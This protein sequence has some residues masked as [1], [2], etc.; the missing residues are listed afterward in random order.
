MARRALTLKQLKAEKGWPYSRQHTNRLIK[1]DKFLRPFKGTAGG[2]LNLFWEDEY[3]AWRSVL[4]NAKPRPTP[5]KNKPDHHD[6]DR[7]FSVRAR[8]MAQRTAR[9]RQRQSLQASSIL[10]GSTTIPAKGVPTNEQIYDP[11]G[12]CKCRHSPAK[13]SEPVSP[14]R[15]AGG[16]R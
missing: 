2:N 6:G 3:D 12:A 14:P 13:Q 9:S 8:L 15:A 16:R 1:A 5:R 11:N 4:P 10:V 7:A